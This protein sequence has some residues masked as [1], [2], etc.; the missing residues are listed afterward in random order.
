MMRLKL[1]KSLLLALSC[2]G[3]GT[4]IVMVQPGQP[5]VAAEQF[6][7]KVAV[8]DGKGG[9]V[10]GTTRTKFPVGTYLLYRTP[11]TVP[12]TQP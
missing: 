6:S 12:A 10:A 5:A 8:S 9:F 2:S 11:A 7:V 3:C 4:Q 1:A